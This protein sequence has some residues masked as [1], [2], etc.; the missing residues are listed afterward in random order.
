MCPITIMLMIQHLLWFS[1]T[2]ALKLP[3]ILPFYPHPIPQIRQSSSIPVRKWKQ[4]PTCLYWSSYR[5]T[6]LFCI[7]VHMPFHMA[8]FD[9]DAAENVMAQYPQ[10]QHWYIAGHSMGGAMASQFASEHPDEVD[11]LILLGALYL[12]RLPRRECPDH[13]WFSQQ[14]RGGAHRL[15]GEHRGDRGRQPCPVWQLRPSKGGFVCNHLR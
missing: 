7:L 2:V 4:K 12:R 11:G 8:I 9:A 3:A 1:R 6:G 10:I 13:L 5:Q 15:H 14:Q